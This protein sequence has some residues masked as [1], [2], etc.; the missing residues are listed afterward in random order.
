MSINSIKKGITI[1]ELFIQVVELRNF[2]F[3]KWKKIFLGSFLGGLLGFLFAFLTPVKYVAKTTFVVEESKASGGLASLAGQFGFDIGGVGS[4]GGVFSGDN[5]LLFLKSES[6]CREALMSPYDSSANVVLADIYAESTGLKKQW[7]KNKKIG[8]I[9]FARF[10]GKKM[11]RKE[12]SLIQYIIKKRVI[13]NDLYVYKPDKKASFIN[14]T[15]IMR[16]EMLSKL[17]TER[18]VQIATKLYVESKTKVKQANVNML[19]RRA[20]SLSAILNNKTFIAASTQQNLIDINPALRTAP[21]TAEIS[22]REKNMVGTIF[23]EVVKNLE[24]SKTILS[25]EVPAI[26]IV[27]ESSLPLEKKKLSKLIYA[28]LG[29]VIFALLFI[30]YFMSKYWIRQYIKPEIGER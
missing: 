30:L 21:I 4:G 13:E 6:L 9:S 3:S 28:V 15:S 24:I 2:V 19:Q 23:A 5:I 12:D 10:I 27:D 16:D 20:D 17:F 22:S 18:L 25:Q 7:R 1:S 8:E 29:G 11:P 26:Q 14:V